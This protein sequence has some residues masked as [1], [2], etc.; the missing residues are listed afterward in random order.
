MGFEFQ[1]LQAEH[2]NSCR[3]GSRCR[4]RCKSIDEAGVER[5]D[6]RAAVL[7]VQFKP[8]GLAIG[9]QVQMGRKRFCIAKGPPLAAQN[10]GDVAV[11]KCVVN[12]LNVLAEVEKFVRP[13]SAVA[14]S[15]R[16]GASKDEASGTTLVSLM[17]G[18]A[19]S[20]PHRSG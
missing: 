8:V 7:D 2:F 10:H 12:E 3:S 5:A 17:A 19:I 18:A 15:S 20:I 6:E 16:V 9:Q 4:A 1:N 14:A 11:V 13:A